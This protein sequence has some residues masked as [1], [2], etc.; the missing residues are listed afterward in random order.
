MKKLVAWKAL[1]RGT[2]REK[3]EHPANR[4]AHPVGAI[5]QLISDLVQR[6]FE[7]I[8]VKEQAK[9]LTIC[10]QMRSGGACRQI[11]A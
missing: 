11:S 5:V 3:L 7:K 9:L 10:R 8:R 2:L 4:D 6:L 1:I